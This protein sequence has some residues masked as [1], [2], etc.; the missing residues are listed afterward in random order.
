VIRSQ[1]DS[2]ADTL[3]Q[4]LDSIRTSLASQQQTVVD[5]SLQDLLALRF[6][7]RD[8]TGLPIVALLGGTG[9][10][11]ST[12]ANRLLET[13]HE[14]VTAAS[15]RRTF[16]AGPV[17]IVSQP[18]RL[19]AAWAGLRHVIADQ[20][21]ARGQDDALIVTT[22]SHPMLTGLSLIDTPDVDGDQPA[23][24]ALA[25]RV[26][27]W[28][29][30]LVFLVSPEKYQMTELQPYYRLA[31]RYGVPS[32][33]V[34]NKADD[35]GVFDDYR[36]QIQ[37]IVGN[38]VRV[39]AVPRDDSTFAPTPAD[40]I[41]GL[42]DAVRQLRP[43]M[44]N[45]AGVRARAGDVASRVFDQTVEPLRQRRSQID[46]TAARLAA[47]NAPDAGVDMDPMTRQL[48]KRMQQRSVLYLMGPGRILDRVKSVPGMLA[49]LPRSTAD[50][51]RGKSPADDSSAQP[52]REDLPD[53]RTMLVDQ[54]VVLQSRVADVMSDGGFAADSTWHVA[55]DR[56]G[57]IVDDETAALK[58]WLEEKWNSSP[59]DTALLN[60]L[61]GKIPGAAR[62]SKYSEAAPY[63]LTIAC[64]TTSTMLGGLDQLV[65]GGYFAATWLGERLSNEVTQ[66]TRQANK[67][68]DRR[69][70]ALIAEQVDVATRWLNAQAPSARAL[71][72]IGET[73]DQIRLACE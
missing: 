3:R 29:Q 62:L 20:R 50:L 1:I 71:D 35:R 26:F 65:L 19:P 47:L 7:L 15:F 17:A 27:R 37:Q 66:R 69:F 44:S 61:I 67:N 2:L 9:T 4:Q 6:H 23:H 18:D 70:A 34:I 63:L 40:S 48:R 24:H 43:P 39:F 68:I 33:F 46:Q 55:A 42:R 45:D 5:R 72:S 30:A 73:I 60:K 11:K 54:F 38:E 10:G 32:L 28:A 14:P 8:L 36:Q 21:P 16:T 31:R 58:S 49:R 51:F 59:R 41:P 53:F 52:R 64:A 25:D 56:A 22:H 13:E 12:I 57:Q